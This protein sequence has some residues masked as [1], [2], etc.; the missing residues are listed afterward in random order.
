MHKGAVIDHGIR[1]FGP[2]IGVFDEQALAGL[3]SV[4]RCDIGFSHTSIVMPFGSTVQMKPLLQC[5]FFALNKLYNLLKL[6][7]ISNFCGGGWVQPVT[8]DPEAISGVKG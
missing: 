3:L 7:H 5:L 4:E 1:K 6:L 8:P 2:C